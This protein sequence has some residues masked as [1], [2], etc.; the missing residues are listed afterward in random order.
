MKALRIFCLGGLLLLYAQVGMGQDSIRTEHLQEVKVNARQH[1]ILTSTSPLQ[2]LDKGDMLRLGVTDM[3]DALHR[4]PGINLRDYGGA[5]GMKTVAVRGFG[6]GHTGVSYDGV[7]L[8]ECQGGEIDVS[9]YSLD[10]V[11]TLRLT[12]GDNDDIFISARQAS[13]AALLAI[14]TMSE[15]PID[16]QPH[17]STQLQV[18]SFGYVSPYL[19]YVQRLSDRFTLQA[20]GEYTYAEND[21]PFLLRN[22]KYTTHERRTNSRMNSGHGE[23]NMHWMMG[24]RADG[25][26]RN[27]L[28]AKIYY[29]DNDRQLP[30][31]VRYY[32][33]VT[34]EQLHDRNAFAQ[35][36]WQARS[37]DDHW[38]LKV[39]AKMN[40]ASS[41]YQDTLVANRRN[42]ATYWQREFYT[43]AALMWMA[44]GRLG[45]GLLCRL[46]DELAQQH[47]RHRPATSPTWHPAVALRPICEGKMGGSCQNAGFS[48][49]QQPG[50]QDR[51]SARQRQSYQ[52]RTGCQGCTPAFAIAFAFL[53]APGKWYCQR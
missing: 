26:S 29:Y 1:R 32:T 8:S 17:L 40:W 19:R 35:A 50:A 2:L 18:G 23:L 46:D 10:Q 44:G 22:G 30:G 28:W 6:A 9:R 33:N 48:L 34:A 11:Q 7:L 51:D 14:E 53:S 49:P 21:Y 13:V 20:M 37:L 15:I 52:S 47:S 16:K 5:G 45:G 39:Q 25:M 12:I 4:M 24:R 31:I 42:D 43:S 41:A 38:M 3:A 36:R 27:Q